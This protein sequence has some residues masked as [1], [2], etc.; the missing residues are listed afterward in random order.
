MLLAHATW[1]EVEAYLGRSDG[2][3]IPLGSIEQHGP[4]GLIG[5]DTLCAESIAT[6]VGNSTG[7]LIAP[8]VSYSPAEFNMAFPGT[9]SL[10]TRT[11]SKVLDEII[12]SLACHGFHQFYF[13]NGHGANIAP[14]AVL[15]KKYPEL[16]MRMKNWWDFR[17]VNALR[18]DLYDAWEG[19]HATPSEVAITRAFFRTVEDQKLGPPEQLDEAYLRAHAGDRHGPPDEHRARFPDGRVGSHS[20]LGTGEHGKQLFDAAC[21]AASSDY[22]KFLSGNC[23][24]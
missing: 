8:T 7:A 22:R 19:M 13:L 5:T 4:I 18:R 6:E 15:I 23:V 9:I 12:D 17:S 2:I 20:D 10:N 1:P 24:D 21:A 16:F 14:L 3:I 11:F